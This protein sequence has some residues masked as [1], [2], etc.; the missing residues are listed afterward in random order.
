[1][2]TIVK[3][4]DQQAAEA[5]KNASILLKELDME[6]VLLNLYTDNCSWSTTNTLEIDFFKRKCVYLLR[7]SRKSTGLYKEIS[8]HL[9]LHYTIMVCLDLNESEPTWTYLFSFL[10]QSRE[11]SKKQALA[12]KREKRK[13]KRKKKKEEQKRKQEEEEGQKTKE[14]SSEMQE[15]KENSAD[16][17]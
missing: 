9:T 12:A 8:V 10:C 13:E 2:E 5:N 11:E 3:A 6:K 14:D 16:G 4:K 15:Q 7:S 1:M 17:I